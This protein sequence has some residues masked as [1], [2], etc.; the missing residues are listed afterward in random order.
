MHG[1]NILIDTPEESKLQLDRAG[2]DVIEACFYSHGHP[3]HTMGRRV[4]ETRNADF[5]GWPMGDKQ[6]LLT[7]V[8]LPQQVAADFRERL[9]SWE[10]LAFMDKQGWIRVHELTDGETVIVGGV[11]IRPF[12]VAESYVYAFELSTGSQRL[13]LAPDELKGWSPPPEVRKSDVAIIPMGICEHDPLTGERRLHVDHPL[14]QVEAT[15]EETL[16]IVGELEA[17]QTILAHIEEMDQLTYDDLVRLEGVLRSDGR[18]VR[19]AYD[20]MLIEV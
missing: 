6:G 8:Y 16:G 5:R 15:F 1:P 11:E 9:G 12:R 4:W 19:F 3:D 2:I 10:H 14:L 20:T 18:N 13:L 7:D 17:R